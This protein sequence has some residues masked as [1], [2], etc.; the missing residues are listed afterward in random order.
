[1]VGRFCP[2]LSLAK[3]PFTNSLQQL[4]A[5]P[6]LLIKDLS[7]NCEHEGAVLKGKLVTDALQMRS[8]QSVLED[9]AG[10]VVTVSEQANPLV[11]CD[12][13][14]ALRQGHHNLIATRHLPQYARLSISDMEQ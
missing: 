6:P 10:D 11:L 1:M 3:P 8:V 7:V 4:S 2:I 12:Q 14:L 5:A 9:E 13:S